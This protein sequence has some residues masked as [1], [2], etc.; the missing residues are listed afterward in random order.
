MKIIPILALSAFM[1]IACKKEETTA[2]ATTSDTGVSETTAPA[3]SVEVPVNETA[4]PAAATTA[5]K[6]VALN[7][8]HGQPGHRCEIAVGAPLDG[9]G[10]KAPFPASNQPQSSS[11]LPANSFFAQKPS[12]QNTAPTPT[13]APQPVAPPPSPQTAPPVP[14]PVAQKT[15]PGFSGKPNPAHGQP[16]HRCDIQVGQILP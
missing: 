13:P 9:S 14:Q 10:S 11:T 7:P 8:P 3:E 1:L 12:A 5:P 15:E 4:A 16:G 6:G 2:I